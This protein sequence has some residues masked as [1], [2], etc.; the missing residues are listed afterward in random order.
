MSDEIRQIMGHIFITKFH[1]P[2]G[3]LLTVTNVKLTSDLKLAYI[4]ISLIASK[5]KPEEVIDYLKYNKKN[6]RYQLGTTLN[7]KYVPDIRFFY[8]D[9]LKKAEEIGTLLNKIK[10][11]NPGKDCK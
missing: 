10:N 7:V 1:I 4:Y 9:T 11:D 3:G 6:I 5:K 8:D 2:D